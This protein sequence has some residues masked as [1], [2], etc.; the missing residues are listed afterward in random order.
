L[1]DALELKEDWHEEVLARISLQDEDVYRVTETW[2][3]GT[4]TWNGQPAISASGTDSTTTPTSP[5]CMTWTVTADVQAI[6]DGTSNFGWRVSDSIED[7]GTAQETI[8]RSREDF[9]V[10]PERPSLEVHFN[11]P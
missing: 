9:S 11:A 7:S 10:P 2:A 8:F 6:V 3:E 4:I 5:G 1:I